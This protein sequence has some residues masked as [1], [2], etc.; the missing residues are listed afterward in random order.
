MKEFFKKGA[1]FLR[2]TYY[3]KQPTNRRQR[4]KERKNAAPYPFDMIH[5][6]FIVAHTYVCIYIYSVGMYVY[7]DILCTYVY[8]H[9]SYMRVK[10]G[11]RLFV[12][13]NTYILYACMYVYM[14]MPTRVQLR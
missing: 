14:Y 2:A 6:V 8:T 4:K 10:M 7:F 9:I 12:C 1:L 13:I 11:V 3:Y 5:A